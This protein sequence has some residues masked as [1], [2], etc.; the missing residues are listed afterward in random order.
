VIRGGTL[1]FTVAQGTT[2]NGID[3]DVSGAISGG[4][5]GIDKEGAGTLALGG[6]DTFAGGVTINGG[7]VMLG[8]GTI[9]H[10]GSITGNDI[11]INNGA[12]IAF[13]PYGSQTVD[14]NINGTGGLTKTGPG[15][16]ALTGQSNY[17]GPTN[18][19]AG[20]LY[21]N[22]GGI[23]TTP[24][25]SVYPGATLG[26]SGP[27]YAPVTV[28]SGGSIEGGFNGSGTLTVNSLT[29]NGSASV[30]VGT[31]ADYGS[32]APV[33]VTGLL[34]TAGS[35]TVTI[36]VS[37]LTGAST[38][39]PYPV[40]SYGTE[41]GAGQ[42]AYIL[43]LPRG[44]AGSLSD[45]AGQVDVTLSNIASSPYLIW[46]GAANA[47]AGWNTTTNNW[48][49]SGVASTY[50]D[51]PGDMVI[52]DDTPGANQTV[53]IKS[54]DVHPT[55]VAF[56]NSAYTYTITGPNAIAGTTGITVNGTGTVILTNNNTFTGALLINSGTLQLGD[57]TSGHDGTIAAAVSI[58]NNGTLAIDNY[59]PL[60]FTNSTTGTGVLNMNG[61][62]AATLTGTISG[63]ESLL[64]TGSGS[65]T[66]TVAVTGSGGVTMSGAGTLTLN[67]P[68]S[69]T[70]L[71]NVTSGTLVVNGGVGGA[72]YYNVSQGATLK[73]GYNTGGGYT[74]GIYLQGSGISSSAGLY[75]EG[76]IDF[77]TNKGLVIDTAPTTIN[78]YGTGSATIQ[79]FDVNT[80]PFLSTTAAAS[81]TVLSPSINIS[82]GSYG[83]NVATI[84]GA[85]TSTG[86]LT[87]HGNIAGSGTNSPYSDGLV[88]TGTG[89]VRLDG[90]NTFT[91]GIDI[92]AGSIIFASATAMPAFTILNVS[93]GAVA[94]SANHGS[95]AKNNLLASPLSIAGASG[96]W[97]GLV[98]LNNNDMVARNG[99][100]GTI[101]N[102]LAQGY[103]EGNWNGTGGIISTAA[104]NSASHLTALGAVA[105]DNGTN[106]NTPLMT[107][108]D[109]VTVSE[110]DVLVKYTY[111]GDANL[112]GTVNSAD[113]ARI[114][115]G[116]LSHGAL[117][118]WFNGDFNY[119]GVINGSDYTLIDNAFNTQ[120]VTIASELALPTAQVA[121]GS[122][123]VPEPASL[124]VLGI[125]AIGLLGRRRRRE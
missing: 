70:G 58:T 20:K 92:K 12:T 40:I 35:N 43:S 49:F 6:S 26:G 87:I 61:S 72:V 125:G 80:G 67:G 32:Q 15:V 83:Y 24:L 33:S 54:G 113:Y 60:T 112:D 109:G 57:G 108:F 47:S 68:N 102:Q 86:D 59:G 74:G 44:D 56:N 119:D 23:G 114:D 19:S 22:G 106:S 21:V 11:N 120:G 88:K 115:G 124:G 97:T 45:S 34:T 50:I 3:L 69:Y 1:F 100:I 66:S 96:A 118:G 9:G 18:I 39:T 38:G 16:T 36:K 64:V 13:N 82:T 122:S 10:D 55:S 94:I 48:T 105:N 51:N 46:T 71:T 93:S 81:G 85:N 7:T 65:V 111:Y 63:A 98:D 89:S 95:G 5:S 29:F 121:G 53:A 31:L 52:F 75:I 14:S 117:T 30:V 107:S 99:S 90:I 79:G 116:F 17:S 4:A 2:S 104:A 42:N 76:G 123:A 84:A 101:T 28:A 27:V 78:T 8:D 73:L 110:A 25:V 41:S 62:G 77:Q 91:T 103:N 37:D